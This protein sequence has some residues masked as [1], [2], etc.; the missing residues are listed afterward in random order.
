MW[1]KQQ[2]NQT[3]EI[4]FLIAHALKKKKNFVLSDI[5]KLYKSP[6]Q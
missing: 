5:E 2:I 3:K 1:L 6:K 4:Y